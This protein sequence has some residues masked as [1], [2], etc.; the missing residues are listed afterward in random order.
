MTAKTLF[1][2]LLVLAFLVPS[3]GW[4]QTQ[5]G[6]LD[7]ERFRQ[8]IEAF[9]NWDAKNSF[10]DEAILFVGSSSIRFWE[11]HKAFPDYPVINRGFGGSMISDVQ[12]F[13]KE[14][15]GKYAPALV[16][17]YAGDN[18]IANEKS[19]AEVVSDYKALTY[20]FHKDFP[21][22]KFVYVPIKPSSSRWDYWP[23]MKEVNQQVKAYNEKREYLYYVDLATPLLG[24]DGTPD[25][26]LFVEDQLH[27]N[28]EGYAVWNQVMAPEL[29]A[30]FTR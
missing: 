13:Y 26:S 30:L 22:A 20:R 9:E 19:V 29:E 28:E 23:A 2:I 8:E 24:E 3:M 21:D 11:T 6:E 14:V 18:D 7:P 16:V 12:Y 1:R 17:F 27:L 4:A 25:D 5:D 10:P 15:I